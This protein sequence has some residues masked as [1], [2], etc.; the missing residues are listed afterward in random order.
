MDKN[1]TPVTTL[2]SSSKKDT[3]PWPAAETLVKIRQFAR[4]YTFAST[5]DRSLGN[6]V[7]N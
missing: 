4:S 5:A 7:L 1:S 3:A 2:I 6:L